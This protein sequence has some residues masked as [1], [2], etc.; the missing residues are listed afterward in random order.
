MIINV[1]SIYK[2]QIINSSSWELATYIMQILNALY[3]F[4]M[5]DF[6]QL[7]ASYSHCRI[8]IYVIM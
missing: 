4:A 6:L 5:Y 1:D 7:T 2:N 8:Q 3:D